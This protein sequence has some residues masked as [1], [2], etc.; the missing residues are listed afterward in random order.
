MTILTNLHVSRARLLRKAI[1]AGLEPSEVKEEAPAHVR[2][3]RVPPCWVS[4]LPC[5]PLLLTFETGFEASP[6]FCA[7]CQLPLLFYSE[8]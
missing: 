3:R 7:F 5:F 8:K 1:R 2:L 6:S 4:S